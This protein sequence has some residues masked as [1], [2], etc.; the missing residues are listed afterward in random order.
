MKTLHLISLGLLTS[1]LGCSQK[2]ASGLTKSEIRQIDSAVS[3]Q[4][5]NRIMGFT[6]ASNGDVTVTTEKPEHFLLRR[7]PTGWVIV[8][9]AVKQAPEAWSSPVREKN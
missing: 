5:T 2:T 8:T 6:V 1:L 9:N 4:T 3:Q 7:S